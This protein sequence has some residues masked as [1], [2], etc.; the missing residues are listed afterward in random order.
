[1]RILTLEQMQ[2]LPFATQL[3]SRLGAE[4][5]KV[6]HPATGDLGRASLPAMIDPA[7]RSVGA[8]FVRN[9]LGKRSIAVDL[10]AP[11]GRQ[12]VLDLAP[13]F[14][15]VCENFKGGALA[16]L[17]LDY[18]DFLAV[19][20]TVIY[21]SISG[22]GNTTDSPYDRGPPTPPWPRR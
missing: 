18:D 21:A 14:D 12:L 11:A 1:M 22:F 13:R 4:V 10:K 6:E 5:V 19:H 9:N 16:R 8:T 7:G 20:P 15:I 17:G 2:A 3:L